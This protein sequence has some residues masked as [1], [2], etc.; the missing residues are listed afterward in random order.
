MSFKYKKLHSYQEHVRHEGR[1]VDRGDINRP[2]SRLLKPV[3]LWWSLQTVTR[4]MIDQTLN[5]NYKKH[6]QK[7]HK[8]L[9]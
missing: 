9:L 3:K 4:S 6:S 2:N 8:K 5:R 1:K 7:N